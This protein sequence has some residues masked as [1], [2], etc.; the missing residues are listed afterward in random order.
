MGLTPS[1]AGI[2][3]A[4]FAGRVRNYTVFVVAGT[5]GP[6]AVVGSRTGEVGS[7]GSGARTTGVIEA[8]YLEM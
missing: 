8:S 6:A 5:K 2:G 1:S 3:R 4:V 7:T